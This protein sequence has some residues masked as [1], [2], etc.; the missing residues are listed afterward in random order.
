MGNEKSQKLKFALII[1]MYNESGNVE[2]CIKRANEVFE[3]HGLDA[4][5]IVVNDGSADN[6]AE[7]IESV[8]KQYKNIHLKNHEV[9]KGF[10]AARK[11]GMAAALE[12]GGYEFVMFMD[13]DMTMDPKYAVDFHN[14]IRDGYDFV[15]GSRFIEGGGMQNVPLYRAMVSWVG[16]AILRVSFRLG[17][18]DYTQGFRAIRTSIVEKFDLK[19]DGFPI[20]VEE[21]YQGRRYTKRFGEVPFILTT[22]KVGVSKFNY[23]PKVF[24]KY[25]S[26]AAKAWVG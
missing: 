3:E 8:R 26:Y 7:E 9:N 2:P 18:K 6:T 12:I 23:T 21:V 11:T 22:R 17:I 13:A 20:I 16:G 4:E 14:K 10:G 5:I 24:L 19:E 25:L 15:I 1:P